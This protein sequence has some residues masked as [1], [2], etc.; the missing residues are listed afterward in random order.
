MKKVKWGVIG[1]GGIADRRTI[2]GMMLAENAELVAVMDANG[3]A[4]ARVKEKYGAKYAFDKME[5][6]LALDEVEAVYIASP[7]FC[8]KEQALAAAR[9]KK[10]ILI[11]KPVGLSV[12]EAQEIAAFCKSE[13]VKL[14]VGF[15]MRFHAYHQKIRELV[16]SGK[17]GEIV[18]MRAQFTCWYPEMENCW[19]QQKHLSGGGAMM[20][21]GV[22]C[23]DILR[24]ISGLEI[25]EVAGLCGN[26]IFKY[27]VEDAGGVIFRMEN[28]AVGYVDA[29]FNIPDA[30]AK[31]KLELYG[32]KGSIFAEGTLSQVEGGRVEVLCADDSTGYDAAQNRSADVKPLELDVTFGNM[33]TKEIEA[34]GR[35]VRGE[36]EIPVCA[37]DGIAS[38]KVIEA[39][40]AT[41]AAR[42]Y[43]KF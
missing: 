5:D 17:I 10:D 13:G 30:A 31:C 40:Y 14:G 37:E 41:S 24:Y 19:R 4:A 26:Q 32:T 8:H 6:L 15:M 42:T 3:E 7:V 29:N 12:A 34:F 28:G 11:E 23:V 27:N 21:L 25:T 35:A 1:C 22:H 43:Q 2:P 39:A 33:Y 38:Q 9:A 20:D 18:S 36:C 16:A